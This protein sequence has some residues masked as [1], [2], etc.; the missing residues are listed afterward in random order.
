[1]GE[2]ARFIATGLL[3]VAAVVALIALQV[4]CDK[5]C[6]GDGVLV[7]T[8]LWFDCQCSGGE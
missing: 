1:M 2:K 5:Q 4:D 8:V 3:L 7:R 6:D